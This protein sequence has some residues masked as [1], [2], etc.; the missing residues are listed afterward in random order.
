MIIK[1]AGVQLGIVLVLL[2][3]STALA[4][5][6]QEFRE[7][8]QSYQQ[9]IKAGDVEKA[10]E[11]AAES[12]RLG[13]KIYGKRSVN[14]ASLAIDYANLLNNTGDTKRARKVLKGKLEVLE[15][16]YGRESLKLVPVLFALGRAHY[17][18]GKPEKGLG[19]YNRLSEILDSHE[20]ELYRAK[21]NFDIAAALLKA[22]GNVDTRMFIQ[23]AHSVYAKRLSGRDLRLG[24]TSYHMG[25]WSMSDRSYAQATDYFNGALTAF[26]TSDGEMGSLEK[27]VREMLVSLYESTGQSAEATP[28]CLALGKARKWVTPVKPLY[29]REPVIPADLTDSKFSGEVR[30]TFTVD[31]SGFVSNPGI[32]SESPSEMGAAA[33]AAIREFRYAPRFLDG[34]PVATD[35]VSF[36]FEFDMKRK[37]RFD[38]RFE[39]PPPRGFPDENRQE[40]RDIGDA[41]GGK[42]GGK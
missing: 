41:V 11:M 28:H 27:T 32:T 31:E 10:A 23:K 26:E 2:T 1:P 3:A 17:V 4:D 6:K 34:K 16:E 36:A 40:R 7:A 20:D 24:L 42:G 12:Y 25:L 38:T 35:G 15:G 39:M 14:A 30:L 8:Y 29:T 22:E 19:H 18:P 9:Y 21:R 5:K 37:P 33:L 13:V